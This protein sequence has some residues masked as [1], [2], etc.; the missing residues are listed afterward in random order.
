MI[1]SKW[2]LSKLTDNGDGTYTPAFIN[3]F[4]L[5]FID[6]SQGQAFLNGKMY[7]MSS[8]PYVPSG[9]RKTKIYVID[10]GGQRIS[11]ILNDWWLR[12]SDNEGE[13]VFFVPNVNNNFKYD[14]ILDIQTRGLYRITF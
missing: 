11:N 3:S 6:T 10:V 7:V 8:N 1:V 14:M 12:I 9:G 2:D 5:P 13:G 4:T